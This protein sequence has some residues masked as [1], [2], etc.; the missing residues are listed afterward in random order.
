M[1]DFFADIFAITAAD[2]VAE[3]SNNEIKFDNFI[4]QAL[5]TNILTLNPGCKMKQ[6]GFFGDVDKV[7]DA[8]YIKDAYLGLYDYLVVKKIIKKNFE[9]ASWW[10]WDDVYTID[11]TLL[12]P[13]KLQKLVNQKTPDFPVLL[14]CYTINYQELSQFLTNYKYRPLDQIKVLTGGSKHKTRKRKAKRS[15]TLRSGSNIREP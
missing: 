3:N 1:W 10:T 14:T 2:K 12:S 6:P 9:G 13:D 4:T 8:S 15:R 11:K 5:N 7:I